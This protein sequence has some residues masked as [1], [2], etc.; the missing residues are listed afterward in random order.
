MIVIL[1]T[2]VGA[3]VGHTLSAP[4][5]GVAV[6][7]HA[8]ASIPDSVTKPQSPNP[9]YGPESGMMEMHFSDMGDMVITTWFTGHGAR[10]ANYSS[11]TFAGVTLTTVS[12]VSDGWSIQY[13]TASRRG[14][15]RPVDSNNSEFGQ[16][17]LGSFARIENL[18]ASDRKKWKV[19][20]LRSRTLLGR[21]TRGIQFEVSGMVMKA[22]HWQNIPLRIEMYMGGPEPMVVTVTKLKTDI[23]VPEDLFRVPS[24]ITL[25]TG[26]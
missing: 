7:S 6:A 5:S 23:T 17:S 24:D 9:G 26:E 16:A 20:P 4:A 25:S 3:L 1:L 21:K 11:A 2:A 10:T 14:T 13:D 12:I 18:S 15:R 22:W 8:T 19:K